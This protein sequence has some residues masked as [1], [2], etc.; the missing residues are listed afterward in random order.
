K[1]RARCPH[2]R[3]PSSVGCC[4]AGFQPALSAVRKVRA[5]CPHHK[6]LPALWG[7][8]GADKV[9]PYTC[10]RAGRSSARHRLL[11]GPTPGARGRGGEP[12]HT[13][14]CAADPVPGEVGPV[15]GGPRKGGPEGPR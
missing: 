4:G 6:D 11:R 15:E 3:P 9:P 14:E 5:R 7:C 1:V 10:P 2:Q 12:R 13:A 8:F